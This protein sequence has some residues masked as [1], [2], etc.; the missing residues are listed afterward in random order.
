MKWASLNH[1]TIKMFSLGK[2][3][4]RIKFFYSEP[5]T[6]LTVNLTTLMEWEGTHSNTVKIKDI[7]FACV[8]PK[9]SATEFSFQSLSLTTGTYRVFW[10]KLTPED[11]SVTIE[12]RSKNKR[13]RSQKIRG[14]W[15]EKIKGVSFMITNKSVGST[16]LA[17]E[18]SFQK[19]WKWFV[20][21]QITM[22]AQKD[23]QIEIREFH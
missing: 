9:H 3:K 21:N 11:G 16:P 4:W 5:G 22:G 1:S 17:R 7:F 10:P 19:R 8:I 14:R 18:L 20:S 6:I 23:L 2:I 12:L 13:N 15:N